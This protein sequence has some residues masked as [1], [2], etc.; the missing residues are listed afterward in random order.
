MPYVDSGGVKL[1]YEET[2][3]GAPI[4][5]IHELSGD[6]RSWEPQVRYFSRFYRC[7][8]YNA[9]GY[10]PSD[11]PDALEAYSQELAAADAVAVLRTLGIDRA[12]LVGLSMGGF[13]AL[14]IGLSY[15]D[16]ARSLVVAGC[17]Y[18]SKPSEVHS[19]R[20]DM[21]ARAEQLEREDMK[22]F[23]EHHAASPYRLAFKRKD[24]R[25]Y[26]E[27]VRQ[28]AGHSR[29]GTALTLRGIQGGR[30]SLW[31]LEQGLAELA[32]PVLIVTGDEDTPCLEPDLFLNS[33]IP[34]AAL[35]VLPQTGHTLNLEEPAMFNAEL[36]SFFSKVEQGRWSD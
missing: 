30:P 34:H 21:H 20:A 33:V 27:F 3:R 24:P 9:R 1:Y 18:G 6:Y 31:D 13:A 10:P 15:P 5:F 28:L 7:I 26:E 11:V 29:L 22:R 19:H 32:M 25:G 2:G 16:F 23:A 17:G 35:W 4:L 36:L 12:H 14:Q 8:T